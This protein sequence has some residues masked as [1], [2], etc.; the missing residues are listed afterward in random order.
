M[1]RSVLDR[2]SADE[3]ML[4]ALPSASGL[5]TDLRRATGARLQADTDYGSW[6]H[7][8]QSTGC[9]SAPT[10]DIH[11]LEAQTATAAGDAAEHDLTGTWSRVAAQLG[12]TQRLRS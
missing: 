2:L 11:Y 6:L 3:S 12:A 10:N 7:D 4:R 8:L 9:Y 1:L 5:V